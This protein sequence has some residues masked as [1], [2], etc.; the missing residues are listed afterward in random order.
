MS[1]SKENPVG[2]VFGKTTTSEIQAVKFTDADKIEIG[3]LVRIPD[4]EGND[5]LGRI[6]TLWT[7]NRLL[8]SEDSLPNLKVKDI[9]SN[10]TI[11][12]LG[13]AKDIAQFV[14]FNITIIGYFNQNTF[15]R[16]RY[17]LHPGQLIY[18]A[19]DDFVRR[20]FKQDDTINIGS[21]RDNPTVSALI[22]YNKLITYH[23]SILA[24]TG[25]GKSYC[26]GVIIEELKLTEDLNL[27]ILILD[28]HSEYS[29]VIIPDL[30]NEKTDL[31]K[32]SIKIFCPGNLNSRHEQL[33]EKKFGRKRPV[34]AIQF[35]PADLT[36]DQIKTLLNQY[37]GLSQAQSREIEKSWD[38][39]HMQA[40]EGHPQQNFDE[41]I[42]LVTQNIKHQGTRNALE[43]KLRVL[44][45]KPFFNIKTTINWSS[46]IQRGF[47][48]IIDFAS[49]NTFDQQALV[50]LILRKLFEMRKLGRIAP[51]LTLIE[52]AHTFIPGGNLASSSKPI[53]SQIASEGRKFGVGIGVI[54]QR[55]SKLDSDVL[56]QCNTH[57]IM[58][59]M[60]PK[61]QKFVQDISEYMTQEDA[62]SIRG[63]ANGEA[64]ILGYAVPF[65]VLCRIKKRLM[66]HGGF[67][68]SLK[69]ELK[70]SE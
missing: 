30:I 32:K 41:M 64:M 5:I 48:S 34:I 10:I 28:P 65:P 45:S 70:E 52:E 1:T 2:M 20:F 66:K 51:F 17:S 50:G 59:L 63:L 22:D 35:H 49:I 26:A 54:S 61:D 13:L 60:N 36:T 56:S 14:A 11:E 40:E 57:I 18:R 21:L 7:K 15:I 23:F 33:F 37:Y 38:A 44:F 58:R 42:Q 19:T 69:E 8:E 4:L 62:E 12:N 47:I 46:F 9:E 31:I 24:M 16:P 29:S 43:T 6:Y 53:I 39:V 27:P 55:P 67:T 25:A 3:M 68:P